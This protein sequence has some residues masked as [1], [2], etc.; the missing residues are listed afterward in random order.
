M[1]AIENLN[2]YINSKINIDKIKKEYYNVTDIKIFTIEDCFE[3]CRRLKNKYEEKQYSLVLNDN[4]EN[5]IRTNGINNEHDKIFR[6]ILGRKED[7]IEII[8]YA[9]SINIKVNDI[10]IY[11]SSYI[12]KNLENRECDIVYKMRDKEIYFLIEHQTKVD[13]MMPFRMQEYICEIIRSYIIGKNINNQSIKLPLVIPIVLYTGYKKWD[14]KQ[15]LSTIQ[16]NLKGY[17]KD[18]IRYN[19]IDINSFTEDE[20]LGKDNFI[21]KV[22]LTQRTKNLQDFMRVCKKI[23][24]DIKDEEDKKLF[25]I[26]IRAT[27]NKKISCEETD[28]FIKNLYKNG[29]DEML[30]SVEMVIAENMKYINQGKRKGKREAVLE[31]AKSMLKEKFTI[32]Q[33]SKVTKLSEEELSKLK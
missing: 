18:L 33:I 19:L 9:I 31:I 5:Y 16:E 6:T 24:N 23:S 13:Y 2:N 8:K 15:E 25:E 10:V 22:M 4:S 30:A 27:L 7:A 11:N 17:T 3:I 32:N 14:A 26:I 12:T 21:S 1:I 29:D 20:L 28:Q